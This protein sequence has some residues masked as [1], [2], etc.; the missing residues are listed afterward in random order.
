[1]EMESSRNSSDQ[2]AIH[3]DSS[4]NPTTCVYNNKSTIALIL[5]ATWS[6]STQSI[7]LFFCSVITQLETKSARW[8]EKR[9]TETLWLT[10]TANCDRMSNC[11]LKFS[12]GCR[13]YSRHSRAH[14][15]S[16]THISQIT[17]LYRLQQQNHV[18]QAKKKR[19]RKECW[20]WLI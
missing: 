9:K 4:A 5:W 19:E 12:F 11:W 16:L 20:L 8:A 7:Y 3:F 17:H 10:V 6:T 2:N 18:Q 1:M 14:T 13:D 15:H